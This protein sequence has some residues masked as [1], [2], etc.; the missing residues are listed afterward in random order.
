MYGAMGP[1]H[2]IAPGGEPEAHAAEARDPTRPGRKLS[3]SQSLQAAEEFGSVPL[4]SNSWLNRG[5][6]G[7]AQAWLAI[8]TLTGHELSG[9]GM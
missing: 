7:K 8:N 9:P 4:L 3:R 6:Y 1:A 2:A 5:Q